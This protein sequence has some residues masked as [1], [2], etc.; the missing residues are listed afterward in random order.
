MFAGRASGDATVVNI[1]LPSAQRALGFPNADRQWIVTAYALA[2]GGLLL[3][4]G[5]IGDMSSRKRV[6]ISGLLGFAGS[7][8]LGGAATSF[9]LLVTARTLQGR[10]ARSWPRLPSAP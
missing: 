2:F 1:A 9:G 8:A 3:L 4:G 5:R 10:S 6:F 7:S